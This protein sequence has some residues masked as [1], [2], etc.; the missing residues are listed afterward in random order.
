LTMPV[1][2]LRSKVVPGVKL[3]KLI[4]RLSRSFSSRGSRVRR[5]AR[6]RSAAPM[7]LRRLTFWRAMAALE[8][9]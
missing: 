8:Q 7:T 9:T 6:A 3:T 5:V 2:D 4:S 1:E